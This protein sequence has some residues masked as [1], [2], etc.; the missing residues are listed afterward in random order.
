MCVLDDVVDY[1]WFI[2]YVSLWEKWI[3]F[4]FVEVL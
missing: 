1:L 2:L 3:D 4:N